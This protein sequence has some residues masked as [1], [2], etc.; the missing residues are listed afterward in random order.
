MAQVVSPGLLLPRSGLDPRQVRMGFVVDKLE[1]R[2][3]LSEYFGFPPLVLFLPMLFLFSS[4]TTD[5]V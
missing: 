5:T 2:E 4:S 1:L 3:V